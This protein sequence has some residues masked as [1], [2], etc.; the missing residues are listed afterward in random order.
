[1]NAARYRR[2]IQFPET[3]TPNRETITVTGKFNAIIPVH[4]TRPA[5]HYP[6]PLWQPRRRGLAPACG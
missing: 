6:S 5:A 2:N 4:I 1:M 3:N